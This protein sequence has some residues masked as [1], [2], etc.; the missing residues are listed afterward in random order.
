MSR[1]YYAF[2]HVSLAFLLSQGEPIERFRHSHGKVQTAIGKRMGKQLSRFVREIYQD[3]LR[4]DYEP[5]FFSSRYAGNI[6]KARLDAHNMIKLANT[7]FYWIYQE[8][9]KVL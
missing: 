7:N 3:R 6:E 5:N 4:A 9:R 1:L 2:F 8:A